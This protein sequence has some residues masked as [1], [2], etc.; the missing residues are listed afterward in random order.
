MKDL[1][2]G[3]GPRTDSPVVGTYLFSNDDH[4]TSGEF[5][6]W[7]QKQIVRQLGHAVGVTVE[8]FDTESG[9]FVAE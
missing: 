1:G 7:L 9:L 5:G 3:D 2:G 6:S 4:E 8:R